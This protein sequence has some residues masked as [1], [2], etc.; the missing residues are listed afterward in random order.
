MVFCHFK[1]GVGASP[2]VSWP[3]K[4]V[5]YDIVAPAASMVRINYTTI[6]SEAEENPPRQTLYKEG[7]LVLDNDSSLSVVNGASAFIVTIFTFGNIVKNTYRFFPCP[8]RCRCFCGS[9]WWPR[10]DEKLFFSEKTK[11]FFKRQLYIWK[12]SEKHIQIVS[13]SRF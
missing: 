8:P 11:N 5:H 13:L 9:D 2:R 7:A 6:V 4:V 3:I 10:M 1:H 12:Y